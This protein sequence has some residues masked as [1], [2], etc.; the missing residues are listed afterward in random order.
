MFD[1][2]FQLGHINLNRGV[3]T[4]VEFGNEV[5]APCPPILDSGFRRN[6]VRICGD[7]RGV[8]GYQSPA[9]SP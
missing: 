8:N 2:V 7:E 4:A 3:V 9:V 1:D 6:D 5:P